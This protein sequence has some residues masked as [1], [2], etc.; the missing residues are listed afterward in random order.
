M[1]NSDF[2]N[3]IEKLLDLQWCIPALVSI[4]IYNPLLL[5]AFFQDCDVFE[6][7]GAAFLSGPRRQQLLGQEAG[8]RVHEE[9]Q[10][11]PGRYQEDGKRIQGN[12]KLSQNNKNT[13][14]GRA[15]SGKSS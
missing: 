12:N 11:Q 15:K 10:R 6:W 9:D 7:V 14:L 3:L 13:V 2:V 1:V 8:R 4:F 5:T